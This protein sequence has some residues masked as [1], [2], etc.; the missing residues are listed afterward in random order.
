M[1]NIDNVT[2]WNASPCHI[3]S[4]RTPS[5]QTSDKDYA[6]FIFIHYDNHGHLGVTLT[7]P[8]LVDL[9]SVKAHCIP[10]E[11][12]PPI[13]PMSTSFIANHKGISIDKNRKLAACPPD[14]SHDVL[15]PGKRTE[16]ASEHPTSTTRSGW[17]FL[18]VLEAQQLFEESLLIPLPPSP[19]PTIESTIDL[20]TLKSLISSTLDKKL[21]KFQPTQPQP[22]PAS[23]P[24]QPPFVGPLSNAAASGE[25][26]SQSL[27]SYF[28]EVEPATITSIIN[29]EFRAN[30][31]YKL[32][33]QY[34]DKT[35]RQVL[36]LKGKTLKLTTNNSTFKDYKS[37]NAIAT[38]LM[39]Y[40]SIILM[41][42][43]A[44]GQVTVMALDFFHYT[45]HLT[46]IA[47]EYEW[48][49]MVAYHMAFFNKCR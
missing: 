18:S 47:S 9:N 27:L 8:G 7:D 22:P 43:G 16:E 15:R 40:F 17:P 34:K 31:L 48:T 41:H 29:H 46:K 11:V 30:D 19:P 4:V 10:V 28:P 36:S 5:Q 33:S 12:T 3:L 2:N 25:L 35:E 1:S 45:A 38:P 6:K 42:A 24:T 37:L 39:V 49:A 23:L 44:T 14:L 21:K 26:P 32:D 20:D 13:V